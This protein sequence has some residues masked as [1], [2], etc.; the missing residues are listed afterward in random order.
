M[1]LNPDC[2]RD[3]LL[4]VEEHC[5]NKHMVRFAIKDQLPFEQLSKYTNDEIEYHINQCSYAGY[6]TKVNTMLNRVYLVQDLS[7]KGHEFLANIRSDTM[8]N[9]V[10]S[11]AAQLGLFSLNAITQIATAVATEAING[12]FLK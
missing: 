7:P 12:H 8:W 2:V 10:K 6:F 9:K 3:I 1:K 5:D 11:R 4:V